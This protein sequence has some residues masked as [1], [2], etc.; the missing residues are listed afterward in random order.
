MVKSERWS[1]IM[2]LSFPHPFR[3]KRASPSLPRRACSGHT[4]KQS[5]HKQE[6]LATSNSSVSQSLDEGVVM[7]V[8]PVLI[9]KKHKVTRPAVGGVSGKL[10]ETTTWE[11]MK[12]GGRN[13]RLSNLLQKCMEVKLGTLAAEV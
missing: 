2:H 8:A 1:E 7:T 13:K 3:H 6:K 10:G 12:C 4:L 5:A 11:Y 9:R